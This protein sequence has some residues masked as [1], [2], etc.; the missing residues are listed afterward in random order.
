[1]EVHEEY[2]KEIEAIHDELARVLTYYEMQDQPED[3]PPY[4]LEDV[5]DVAVWVENRLAE[6]I[7]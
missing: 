2:T 6:L 5:Y 1:M 4:T 7:N 3:E